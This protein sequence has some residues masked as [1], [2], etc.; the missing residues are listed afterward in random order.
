MSY[1]ITIRYEGDYLHVQHTGDDS[2]QISLALW[3][4]ISKACEKHKCFNILGESN[5]NKLL[6]TMDAFNHIEIFRDAG[7]THKYRIAWVDHNPATK[8]LFKFIETVLKNRSVAIG[9]L[10]ENVEEA[11]KWLLKKD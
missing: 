11:M 5:T 6:S 1:E 8:H 3:R 7:I 4:R 9:G 2:Y 10:F